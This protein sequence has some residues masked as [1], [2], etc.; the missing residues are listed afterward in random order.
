[1]EKPVTLCSPDDE[2]TCFACCPPIRPAGYEHWEHK[3]I[4]RRILRENPENYDGQDERVIPITGFSCWALGYLDGNYKRIGCLLHPA[5]NEGRDLRHRVDYGEKCRRE[6]CPE[7]KV[8]A[9]LAIEEQTFWLQL[10]DGLDSFAYSSRKTNP[11]FDL[12]DWGVGILR[13]IASEDRDRAMS[14]DSFFRTFPLFET[15]LRPRANAYLLNRLIARRGTS[16]LREPTFRKVFEDLSARILTRLVDEMNPAPGGL[17]IHRLNLDRHYC[18][19]LRLF[20]PLTRM[21]P[22]EAIRLKRIVDKEADLF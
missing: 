10:A 18:D 16:I 1:M 5:R 17:P 11:L 6:N 3:N 19:L 8:F 9:E 20:L 12:M 7:A 15:R 2:K 22:D 13:Q 21:P 4:I 14:V